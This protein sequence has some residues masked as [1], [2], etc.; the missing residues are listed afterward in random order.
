MSRF[1]TAKCAITR[2]NVSLSSFICVWLACL[3]L[4]VVGLGF[5]QANGYD[6]SANEI[7]SNGLGRL[8]RMQMVGGFYLLPYGVVG[9]S[10]LANLPQLAVSAL[11]LLYNDLVTR[12]YLCREWTEFA[13]RRRGLRVQHPIGEQRRAY[14]L[15]IPWSAA[16]P[17]FILMIALHWLISQSIFFSYYIGQDYATGGAK[18][19]YYGPS[20]LG[21]GWSPLGLV[22]SL[23]VGGLL[24]LGLWMM[25]L[26][27]RFPDGIP[28]VRTHS[29][30]ISAACHPREWGSGEAEKAVQ[31]GSLPGVFAPDGRPRASFSSGVVLPLTPGIMYG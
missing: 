15:T 19:G 29:A 31:Y 25:A 10:V 17:L 9:C 21:V 4:L 6:K 13:R 2:A 24:I 23:A 7:L 1:R 22:L 26:I 27:R 8:N 14:L 16:S 30:A 28:L 18:P 3:I 20:V 11:Y 12:M 5:N